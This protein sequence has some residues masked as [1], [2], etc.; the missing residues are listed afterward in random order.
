MSKCLAKGFSDSFA[1]VIYANV[2]YA[3]PQP[4]LPM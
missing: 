1:E 2:I 4:L 3:V